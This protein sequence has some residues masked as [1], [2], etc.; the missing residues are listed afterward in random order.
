M[1]RPQKQGMDYF[2]HDTDASNDEKVE[3]LRILYGNDGYA[4]YFILLERIYRT[5]DFELDISDAETIQ[6][7]AKK[8]EV[9]P[10]KFSEMLQ[11]SLKRGCFCRESYEKRQVLTSTGI[12]KRSQSVV[13][14]RRNMANAY[15][16]SKEKDSI[17]A[18][19]GVSDAETIPE[20]PVSDEF[21][22]REKE[23][24]GE[25][26]K[27]IYSSSTSSPPAREEIPDFVKANREQLSETIPLN[28][29]QKVAPK[30][31]P[32][33]DV[34]TPVQV[35][36]EYHQRMA[37]N[38]WLIEDVC[39][40]QKISAEECRRDLDEFIRE[41]KGDEHIPKDYED[42]SQ[43]FKSWMRIRYRIKNESKLNND[44]ATSQQPSSAKQ[45]PFSGAG[46]TLR[47]TS[48]AHSDY[49]GKGSTC[50]V[51]LRTPRSA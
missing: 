38:Q 19:Q 7:L 14:K 41:K 48:R 18:N 40:K 9:K 21:P 2:P 8:V 34:K 16:E 36:D 29:F 32:H 33:P 6:I 50:D 15:Q 26:S 51:E 31:F 35:L 23:S 11:T 20:T 12:K 24:R 22:S 27:E 4:F 46:R 10:E 3:A 47:P 13:Q 28:P 30:S 44:H 42:V 1:A 45:R 17:P 37:A 39:M 25:E 5:P 43:H 49:R